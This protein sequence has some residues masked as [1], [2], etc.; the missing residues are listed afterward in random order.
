MKCV[1]VY[2]NKIEFFGDVKSIGFLGLER[3]D[4]VKISRIF[5]INK[6]RFIVK[7]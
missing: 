2:M 6:G 1:F 4:V 5:L 7:G 3:E